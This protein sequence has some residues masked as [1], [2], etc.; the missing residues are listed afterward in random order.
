[1]KT[2]IT[3]AMVTEY[4]ERLQKALTDTS[5]KALARQ[6]SSWY[7]TYARDL[8]W[9]KR[10]SK[11]RDPY[12]IWVSEIMLQ[13]TVIKAV[14]S[15]YDRF[16]N[17]FPRLNDLA[18]A[19]EEEVRQASRG[20]GYYRRFGLLHKAA[21]ELTSEIDW[22]WPETFEEWLALPGIG[23]YTAAAIS[24]I[25]FD[26]PS[27]VVDG[28]VER[29]FCRVFAIK[30]PVGQ[31]WM[32]KQF[33]DFGDSIIQAVNPS[34]FNQGLME[35]GQ[36]TCT[37][38]SPSC[39]VCPISN[40]CQAAKLKIQDEVPEIK[41]RAQPQEISM[42]LMIPLNK[43]G[44]I[45]LIKRPDD[46]RFLKGVWGFPTLIKSDGD[47]LL[48][49]N[50]NRRLKLTNIKERSSIKHTIT[51]YRIK[52]EVFEWKTTESDN[53]IRWVEPELLEEQLV[54][55]LDRKALVSWQKQKHLQKKQPL[56]F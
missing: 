44:E 18:N 8:P 53:N 31:S 32:K 12:V 1:M 40:L 25:C 23:T 11:S 19:S 20:L 6:I 46:A 48:D 49:G 56:L 4:Q 51:K 55:N 9:R 54:A 29:V 13:Q 7:Q 41:K 42:R 16:L 45:G 38:S 21:K 43:R 47:L 17:R 27:A 10:W 3:K 22:Q 28:N 35:L 39:S 50:S 34:D 37:K 2:K 33:K 14:L 52:A 15:V 5:G 30:E 36:T 24:S 26:Y